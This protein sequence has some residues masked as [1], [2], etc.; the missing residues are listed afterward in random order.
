[1]LQQV[2]VLFT[3]FDGA[4]VALQ[5]RLDCK[6]LHCLGLQVAVG[7][8]VSDHDR[9]DAGTAEDV[10]E[11]A[12]DLALAATGAHGTDRNHRPAAAQHGGVRA[13]KAEVGTAGEHP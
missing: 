10:A 7:H 5:I 4:T 1:V 13:D 2:F 3:F 6:P 12:D 9:P 11:I 8:G